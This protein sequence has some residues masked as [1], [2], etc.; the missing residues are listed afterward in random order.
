M[1]KIMNKYL[2]K[3]VAD[4]VAKHEDCKIVFKVF[5]GYDNL[6]VKKG[7]SLSGY[8]CYAS[9]ADSDYSVFVSEVGL[10]DIDIVGSPNPVVFDNLSDAYYFAESIED[11]D[12]CIRIKYFKETD[13]VFV[14][15]DL[16]FST[17]VVAVAIDEDNDE[18]DYVEFGDFFCEPIEIEVFEQE[19]SDPGSIGLRTEVFIYRAKY[20][21]TQ[22]EFAVLVGV[23]PATLTQFEKYGTVSSLTE[24]KIR[25]AL[26]KVPK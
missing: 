16:R 10:D 3:K 23:S 12:N 8:V 20:N 25:E 21:L 18:V 2:E 26:K 1:E 14:S 24:A 19:Q 6:V 7:K 15:D 13:S 22:A 17:G 4:F 5:K 9:I 11:K